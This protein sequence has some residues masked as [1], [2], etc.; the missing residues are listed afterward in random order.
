MA[1]LEKDDLSRATN[2]PMAPQRPGH[3]V[4][5]LVSR[6]DM[7]VLPRSAKDYAET[8]HESHQP[9]TL[10]EGVESCALLLKALNLEL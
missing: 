9:Q 2:G 5:N 10:R 6:T 7:T 1:A 4:P 8:R 3:S